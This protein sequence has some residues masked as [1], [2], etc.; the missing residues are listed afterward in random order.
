MYGEIIFEIR[1]ALFSER[2]F[3]KIE[4]IAKIYFSFLDQKFRGNPARKSKRF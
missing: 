3:G 2:V 1:D 4:E